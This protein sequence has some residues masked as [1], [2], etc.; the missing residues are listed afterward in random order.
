[1]NKSQA[2]CRQVA[3]PTLGNADGGPEMVDEQ[4]INPSAVLS[5][6]PGRVLENW[7]PIQLGQAAVFQFPLGPLF[8]GLLLPPTQLEAWPRAVVPPLWLALQL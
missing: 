5:L 3:A 8:P 6:S 1:M 2:G 7:L 4:N